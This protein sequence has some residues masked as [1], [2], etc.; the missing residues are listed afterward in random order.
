[1][2]RCI[3]AKERKKCVECTRPAGRKHAHVAVVIR[4]PMVVIFI[5]SRAESA[6]AD[7]GQK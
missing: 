5:F 1:M 3:V 6:E 2:T 7:G 4:S